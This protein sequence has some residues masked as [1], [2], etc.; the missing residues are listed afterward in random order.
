MDK[1]KFEQIILNT[2]EDLPDKFKEKIKNL[3]VVIEDNDIESTLKNKINT[4]ARLTLGLY[5]GLHATLRPGR[6][7]IMPDK[8]TI[9]KYLFKKVDFDI[10]LL[11]Q[12]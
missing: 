7:N 8:I 11:F 2:L 10:C 3:C 5:Q 12:I 4:Q 6:T 1:D 9:Y